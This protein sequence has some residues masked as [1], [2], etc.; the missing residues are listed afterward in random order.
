MFRFKENNTLDKR[1]AEVRKITTRWPGRIPVILERARNSRLEEF[2]KSKFLCPNEY[3]VQQFLSCLRK[4]I[5]MS[6]D[7]ALFVFVNG[8]ELV[9]GDTPMAHLYESKK[10][11]DGFIYMI[12]SEQEVLGMFTS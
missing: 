7:K 5:K 6:R 3:T 4:K 11:E 9:T 8:K 12:Y 1:V 10:D 2:E